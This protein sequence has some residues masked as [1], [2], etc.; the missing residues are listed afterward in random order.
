MSKAGQLLAIFEFTELE[1]Q[2]LQARRAMANND[3][4]R[5][6]QILQAIVDHPETDQQLRDFAT[7]DINH[8]HGYNVDRY[9]K[10][11]STAPL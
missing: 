8:L 9:N 7:S 2:Y 1:Q 4:S 11:V 5:A 10:L 3:K 6:L